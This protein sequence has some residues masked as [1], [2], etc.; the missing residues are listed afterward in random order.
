MQERFM[1]AYQRVLPGLIAS[2]LAAAIS[3]SSQ[4]SNLYVALNT[5]NEVAQFQNAGTG[6]AYSGTTTL[7]YISGV[8]TPYGLALDSSGDFYVVSNSSTSGTLSE[9]GPSG[10]STPIVT[11][12]AFSTSP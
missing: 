11:S 10:G 9:Y 1:C 4:A 7:N 6:S 3:S 5:G 12:G 2:V 8:T